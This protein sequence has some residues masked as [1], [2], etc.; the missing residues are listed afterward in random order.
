MSAFLG[1]I[2]HKM[3]QK[4]MA[5]SNFALQ[6]AAFSDQQGWTVDLENQIHLDFPLPQGNL[7]EII[8]LNNIHGWLSKHVEDAEMRLAIAVQSAVKDN[9]QHAEILLDF[10]R[11]NAEQAASFAVS[12]SQNCS[13][14]WQKMDLYWL[15]GMPCDRGVQF[16]CTDENEVTWSIDPA[17]HAFG[18]DNSCVLCYN[19]LRWTWLN[20][21]VSRQGFV[22]KRLND[23]TFCLTKE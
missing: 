3:Y 13:E 21:F 8:D 1:P 14:L 4:I 19:E 15:D 5:Q 20:A 22:L 2:H 17:Q 18:W 9:Q 7:E 11:S 23:L 6:I 16:L 12:P 10:I